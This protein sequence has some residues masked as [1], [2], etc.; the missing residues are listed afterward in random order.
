M[1]RSWIYTTC[2]Y[3]DTTVFITALCVYACEIK[4]ME[5]LF[6]YVC[7]SNMYALR[8]SSYV[9]IRTAHFLWQWKHEKSGRENLWRVHPR[10]IHKP[11]LKCHFLYF[12][13]YIQNS[14]SYKGHYYPT[15]S[16]FFDLQ[17]DIYIANI[18]NPVL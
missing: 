16:V 1:E 3:F 11:T 10:K 4:I 8:M 18:P 5:N 14:E 6:E 15:K 9:K 12:R 13:E 2:N 7:S 17:R